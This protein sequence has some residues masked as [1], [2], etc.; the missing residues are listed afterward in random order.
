MKK[1]VENFIYKKLTKEQSEKMAKSIV[2]KMKKLAEDNSNGDRTSVYPFTV[3]ALQT[4]IS[5]ILRQSKVPVWI[6]EDHL[7]EF[8]KVE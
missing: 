7:E 5:E 1:S 4:E 2:D 6:I 8:K 3:G